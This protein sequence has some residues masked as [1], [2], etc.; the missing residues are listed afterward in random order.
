MKSKNIWKKEDKEMDAKVKMDCIASAL[1]FGCCAG[2][3]AVQAK[4]AMASFPRLDDVMIQVQA[5]QA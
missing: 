5:L 4:G 2:G 1:K 3:L